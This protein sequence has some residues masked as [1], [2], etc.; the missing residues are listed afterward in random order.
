MRWLSAFGSK[1]GGELYS[2]PRSQSTTHSSLALHALL[3][4]LEEDQKYTILD[5]G[6]AEGANVE[7]FSQIRCTLYIEDLYQAV[8]SLRLMG[9]NDSLQYEELFR[10]LLPFKQGFQFDIV[11][12][13]DLLNYL[14]RLEFQYMMEHLDRYCR[15]GTLLFALVSTRK[16]IPDRPMHFKILGVDQLSYGS[17]P[18]ALT[19]APRFKETELEVLMP[20]FHAYKCFLLRNGMKEYLFIRE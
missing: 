19:P 14:S 3:S 10:K 17:E 7:F 4:Q 11:L 2:P 15:P 6:A 16:E 8:T 13:W 18:A 20:K 12:A 1:S 5:L 9:P